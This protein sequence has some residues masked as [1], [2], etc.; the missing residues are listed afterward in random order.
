MGSRGGWAGAASG[1]GSRGCGSRVSVEAC[2]RPSVGSNNT[3]ISGQGLVLWVCTALI[4]VFGVKGCFQRFTVAGIW[5]YR[6]PRFKVYQSGRRLSGSSISNLR[7]SPSRP[8]IGD[9]FSTHG[10]EG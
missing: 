8:S 2:G 6:A 7:F 3:H 5:P 4:V 1:S 9:G 10:L